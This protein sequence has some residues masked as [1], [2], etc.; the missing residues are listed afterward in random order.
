MA[1]SCRGLKS[2]SQDRR[3]HFGAHVAIAQSAKGLKTTLPPY[4]VELDDGGSARGRTVLIAVGSRYRRLEPN[5]SPFEGVGVYYGATHVEATVCR[6]EEVAV[7][8]GGNSAGQAAVFRAVS[9]K[10]V[11]LVVRGP[12]L[13][14]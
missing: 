2:D 14:T 11:Y 10:H 1:P 8:G 13:A 12:C 9:A 7:V 3:R 5:L 4:T 6:D